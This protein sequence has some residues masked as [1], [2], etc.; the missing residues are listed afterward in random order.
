MHK[1]IIQFQEGVKH[2][3]SVELIPDGNTRYKVPPPILKKQEFRAEI[4]AEACGSKG[5]GRVSE[6]SITL[7]SQRSEPH[8]PGRSR[9]LRTQIGNRRPVMHIRVRIGTQLQAIAYGKTEQ[10]A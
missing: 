9:P 2:K 8:G 1:I 4:F 10:E 7:C 3:E 5:L 6:R